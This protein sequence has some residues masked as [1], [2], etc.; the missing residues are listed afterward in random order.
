MKVIILAGGL[1]TRLAEETTVR[2][3]ARNADT[4][5]AAAA[6][7]VFAKSIREILSSSPGIFR[8]NGLMQS[9]LWVRFM[10]FKSKYGSCSIGCR[11]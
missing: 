10:I 2:A 7:P 6:V 4:H 11:N 3:A 8:R 5:R 1:G 9:E